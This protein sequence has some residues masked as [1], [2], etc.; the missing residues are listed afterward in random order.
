[1]KIIRSFLIVVVVFCGSVCGE[2]WKSLPG[3]FSGFAHGVVTLNGENVILKVNPG[4]GCLIYGEVVETSYPSLIRVSI[5]VN[6]PDV[7]LVVGVLNGEF[8]KGDS[9]WSLDSSNRTNGESLL[10][11]NGRV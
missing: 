2:N 3:G 9:N 8:E 11:G 10:K 7:N 1:M 6:N 5:S 4:K